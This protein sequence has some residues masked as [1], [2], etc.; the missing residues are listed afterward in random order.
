M[1]VCRQVMMEFYDY[2]NF[3][4]ILG[5]SATEYVYSKELLPIGFGPANLGQD[6]DND[7]SIRHYQIRHCD[8]K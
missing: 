2:D 7:T 1:W 4:V 8:Y 3:K 5:K 6:K